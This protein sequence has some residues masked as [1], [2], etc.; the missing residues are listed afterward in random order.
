MKRLFLLLTILGLMSCGGPEP[1]KPVKVKS[2]SFF[3]ETVER[4]KKLLAKEEGII[5]ELIKECAQLFLK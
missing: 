4:N 2:G 1:R 3:T 5:Q